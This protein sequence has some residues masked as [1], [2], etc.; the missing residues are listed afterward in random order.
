MDAW[1]EF[2]SNRHILNLLTLIS[3]FQE[4]WITI[5]RNVIILS[6]PFDKEN[7][8]YVRTEQTWYV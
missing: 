8:S 7:V 4:Y 3:L 1:I 2:S 6:C 5:F